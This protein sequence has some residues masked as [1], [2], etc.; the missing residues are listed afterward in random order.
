[1]FDRM[2]EFIFGVLDALDAEY[3][4]DFDAEKYK[5]L[6][7]K[8][9]DDGLFKNKAWKTFET[10]RRGFGYLAERLMSAWL[11]VNVP[12]EDIIFIKNGEYKK[13]LPL[14]IVSNGNEIAK[15][16]YVKKKFPIRNATE[17]IRSL[18]NTY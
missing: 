5:N 15:T 16:S 7:Q 14:P 11:W 2:A 8:R 9:V 18:Y 10:Q 3:G 1:M 4:L 12:Q 6:Y 17:I 13:A